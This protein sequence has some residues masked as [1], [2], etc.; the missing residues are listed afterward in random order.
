[1]EHAQRATNEILDLIESFRFQ[2]EDKVFGLS[3]S[4]GLVRI[5]STTR[6]GVDCLKQADQAC[7]AAKEG[8]RNQCVM[9]QEDDEL[10]INRHGE[11]YWVTE[12]ADAHLEGRFMLYAQP[13]ICISDRLQPSSYEILLRMHTRDG[14]LMQP[15]A[16]LP[17]AE[18]YNIV[19][20]ID[21]WV[22]ENTFSW[23]ANHYQQMPEGTLFSINLSGLSI[24]KDGLLDYILDCHESSKVPAE[25]IK[26]E[27]T[28]TAAIRNL[29]EASAFIRKL[30]EHGFLFALDDFGSGLSS[31]AYL[32]NLPVDSLK[33][34]GIFVKDILDDPID[35]AMVR[36][37]N[38][39]G[40]VMGIKTIAEFVETE[41][42]MAR[43]AEI[44]VDYAQGYTIDKPFPLDNLLTVH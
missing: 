43:L 17:A 9:Y 42:I 5:D 23:L 41:Q 28:E 21:R 14:R 26:F 4:I 37:I 35:E 44:G 32:K 24:S 40:H 15:G 13:I 8:G 3:A 6:S 31:F 10:L 7:Y 38:E 36:S 11:M 25:C 12:L 16:F 29:R 19:P 34:D 33:I 2:W 27:I 22:I 30:R 20:R 18:R 1:M 39:I